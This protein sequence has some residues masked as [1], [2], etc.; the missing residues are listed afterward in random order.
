MAQSNVIIFGS[1]GHAKVVV[2]CIEKEGKHTI[3]GVLDSFKSKS[4]TF[5]NYPIL[6]N[7][8]DISELCQKYQ[9]VKFFIAIGDN[10][11]RF[12][13]YEKIVANHANCEF[14]STIHPTAY[15]GKDVEIAKGTV[16][17]ANTVV[18]TSAKIAEFC[19]L[20]TSSILEHD[21]KM[22]EFSSLGPGGKTG[23]NVKIGKFSAIGIGASIIEKIEIG[24]H[25]II[26]AGSVIVRNHG[27]FEKIVGVPGKKIGQ[28]QL[29]EK[30]LR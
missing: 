27:N 23:G 17:L 21:S 19:I 20:N 22:D 28:H 2:D 6:G 29:G 1:S 12:L 26:G 30:Y 3:L 4:D 10:Y 14:I 13:V 5:L 9:A 7:E 11:S 25:T 16:V 8:N 18:N 15:I 24:E